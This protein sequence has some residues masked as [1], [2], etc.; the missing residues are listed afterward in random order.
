M[1]HTAHSPA[2][3]SLCLMAKLS[4]IV[5]NRGWFLFSEIT[6]R[7]SRLCSLSLVYIIRSILKIKNFKLGMMFVEGK[8]VQLYQKRFTEPFRF[9]PYEDHCIKPRLDQPL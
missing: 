7:S 2:E 1:Y 3:V 5:I 4:F 9:L 6:L 8:T